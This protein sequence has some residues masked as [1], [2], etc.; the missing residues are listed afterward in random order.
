MTSTPG[1]K[2]Q[3]CLF[4]DLTSRRDPLGVSQRLRIAHMNVSDSF[5]HCGEK[6]YAPLFGVGYSCVHVSL[7]SHFSVTLGVDRTAVLKSFVFP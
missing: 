4:C 5:L 2:C 1:G 7:K 3:K 6:H